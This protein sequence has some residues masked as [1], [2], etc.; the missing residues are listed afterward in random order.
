VTAVSK[1]PEVR[2][3][4]VFDRHRA[5]PLA[6]SLAAT[7]SNTPFHEHSTKLCEGLEQDLN[8]NA[9]VRQR[10]ALNLVHSDAQPDAFARR[11]NAMRNHGVDTELLD[12]E[13]GQAMVPLLGFDN[14][15]FPIRS[16]LLQRRGGTV[17]HDATAWSYARATGQPGAWTSASTPRSPASASRPPD[18]IGAAFSDAATRRGAAGRSPQAS[19]RWW[20]S[21]TRGP[22][23]GCAGRG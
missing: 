3:P 18:G 14:E 13:A 8:D 15:R 9:M 17:R 16:G 4:A 12:R 6:A 22:C 19:R 23:S 20:I 5:C 1:R 21:R 2:A 11:G 7:P 10:G